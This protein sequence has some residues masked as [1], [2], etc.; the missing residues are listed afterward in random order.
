MVALQHVVRFG[1]ANSGGAAAGESNIANFR[2]ARSA[3]G[4]LNGV[5]EEVGIAL[6]T[7]R[8]P[9]ADRLNALTTVA[10]IPGIITTEERHLGNGVRHIA[11]VGIPYRLK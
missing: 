3:A 8:D 1:D 5:P 2:M 10:P 4:A 7:D 11:S 6:A 9:F